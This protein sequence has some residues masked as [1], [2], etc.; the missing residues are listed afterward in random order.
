[1]FAVVGNGSGDDVGAFEDNQ[2]EQHGTLV[3]TSVGTFI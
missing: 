1:V 3:G 2:L